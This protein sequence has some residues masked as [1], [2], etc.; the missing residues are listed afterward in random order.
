[1][2]LEDNQVAESLYSEICTKFRKGH[3]SAGSEAAASETSAEKHRLIVRKGIMDLVKFG[4]LKFGG[5]LAIVEITTVGSI[6]MLKLIIDMMK[7]PTGCTLGYKISVFL[8]FGLLRLVSIFARSYYDL[9]VYNYF[10][11]VQTQI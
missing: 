5:Q 2:Y 8:T 10:R 6:F 1:M 3:G 9:D 4:I 11:Y 7:D